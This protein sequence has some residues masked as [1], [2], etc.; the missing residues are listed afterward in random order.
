MSQKDKLTAQFNGIVQADNEIDAVFVT[1]T[2]ESVAPIIVEST[3]V[4]S[5]REVKIAAFGTQIGKFSD[6]LKKTK[7]AEEGGLDYAFFQFSK[8]ITSITRLGEEDKQV[9]LFMISATADGIAEVDF[10]RR[11]H[12]PKIIPELKELGV[13]D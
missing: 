3:H 6:F 9:F 13:I 2:T 12:L 11:E 10:H 4:N 5:G 1:P 7:L 8:G